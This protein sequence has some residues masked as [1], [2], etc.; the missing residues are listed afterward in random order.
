[1]ANE[2]QPIEVLFRE[3]WQGIEANTESF[4]CAAD[5]VDDDAIAIDNNFSPM[6]V[7]DREEI[8]SVLNDLQLDIDDVKH[9]TGDTNG[10]LS[11]VTD[12]LDT[13]TAHLNSIQDHLK[14]QDVNLDGIESKLRILQQSVNNIGI[15][16]QTMDNSIR[17]MRGT[18]SHMTAVQNQMIDT[19]QQ[20]ITLQGQT[21]LPQASNPHVGR[22]STA[23]SNSMNGGS[24][25]SGLGTLPSGI[26]HSE[27]EDEDEDD[28]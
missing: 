8:V 4:A 5:Q 13:M 21:V 27:D 11:S 26:S 23:P 3:C 17:T 12:M 14:L 10:A 6:D 24:L 15:Q 20:L 22:T 7:I 16:Q 2:N 9:T 25:P 28:S 19:Q 1:M 18:Q